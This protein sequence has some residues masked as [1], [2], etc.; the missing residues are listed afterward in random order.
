MVV[1]LVLCFNVTDAI[2]LES[3]QPLPVVKPVNL[4]RIFPLAGPPWL[5][6]RQH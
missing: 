6:H 4:I 2:G 3:L 1:E 5:A